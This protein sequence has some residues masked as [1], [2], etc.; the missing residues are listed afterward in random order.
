MTQHLITILLINSQ[1]TTIQN[2]KP[3]QNLR[4]SRH[5]SP[6]KSTI[7]YLCQSTL[8]SPP[9]ALTTHRQ[10]AT[11]SIATTTFYAHSSDNHPIRALALLCPILTFTKLPNQRHQL[12]NTHRPTS[13]VPRTTTTATTGRKRL[14]KNVPLLS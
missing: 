5:R 9:T 8:L 2:Q 10:Q 1:S 13:V 4:Q 7:S 11:I 12:I 3:C 14:P 6:T